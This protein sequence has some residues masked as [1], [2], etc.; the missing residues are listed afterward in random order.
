MSGD[1]TFTMGVH[2]RERSMKTIRCALIVAASCLGMTVQATVLVPVTLNDLAREAGA[3]VRGRVVAV[4]SR[5]A[6]DRRAIETIVTV[7]AEQTLKGSLGASVQFVVPGGS[8]GRY[9]SIVVGAPVFSVDQRVIV[10]LGWQGPSYPFLIGFSQGVY[11]IQS[12]GA[13]VSRVTPPPISLPSS[14]AAAI[15]R[16]D[17]NRRPMPLVEF[18]QQVRALIEQR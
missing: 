18:E 16:G 11:R 15:V 7:E 10:F 17:P 3:I 1:D 4:E 6:L 12:D 8:V 5:V 13:G 14:P 9:R 2:K